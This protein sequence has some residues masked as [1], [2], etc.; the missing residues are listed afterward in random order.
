MQAMH[1]NE[2]VQLWDLA[3]RLRLQSN[4]IIQRSRMKVNGILT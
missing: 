2:V 3:S 1:A 4:C